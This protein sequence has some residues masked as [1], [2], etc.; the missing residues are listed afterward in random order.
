MM[1]GWSARA[2]ACA[3]NS[4]GT[5][6]PFAPCRLGI[7]FAVG[8]ITAATFAWVELTLYMNSVHI[9]IDIKADK[10]P[11]G[12][13]L[14]G[15]DKQVQTTGERLQAL[16]EQAAADAPGVLL[17]VHAPLHGLDWAGAAGKSSLE[18]GQMLGVDA[19]FR[20]ASMSKTFT[21]VLVAQLMERG[22]L[23]L[24]DSISDYLPQDIAK[25]IPVADG[26]LPSDITIEHLLGHRGGFDDFATSR[27][28]FA[29]IASDPGRPRT[30]AD[31]I[32][33]PIPDMYFWGF[34]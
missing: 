23:A 31:N 28:W 4:Q 18:G 27:E 8:A 32:P 11:V 19:G 3:R 22:A 2:A 7:A 13:N 33:T 12:V 24:S 20:I 26:H 10:I 6:L 5:V 1:K 21:G 17:A 34:C 14:A 9:S 29:E 15:S 25:I 30:P 16:I